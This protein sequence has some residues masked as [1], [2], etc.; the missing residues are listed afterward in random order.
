[1]KLLKN[2][3]IQEWWYYNLFVSNIH[4]LVSNQL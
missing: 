4:N 1:V 2:L 3:T